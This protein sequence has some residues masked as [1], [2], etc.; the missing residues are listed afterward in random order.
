LEL[1]HIATLPDKDTRLVQDLPEALQQLITRFSHVFA[2]SQGLP[3]ARDCDHH[4]PL[5]PG[6]RP[7]QIRPYRYAPVLK[8][9]IE[10][11]LAEML[12]SCI[13]EH[14]KSDFSSS[15]I[16][17]RKKDDTYRFCVDYRHLNAIT[18]KKKFPVPIIE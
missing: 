17:V 14:S 4:I 8:T 18:A 15:V 5:L 9:E 2:L 1:C 12:K 11:Q 6:V 13:I 3:P 16:L 10:K 7:V